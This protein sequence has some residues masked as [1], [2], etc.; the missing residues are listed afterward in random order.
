M[1]DLEVKANLAYIA[2]PSLE[3]KHMQKPGEIQLEFAYL[4]RGISVICG[5]ILPPVAF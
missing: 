3:I 4:S 2:R 1:G 5:G